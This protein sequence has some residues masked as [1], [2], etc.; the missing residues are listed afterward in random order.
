VNLVLGRAGESQAGT[1]HRSQVPGDFV[2]DNPVWAARGERRLRGDNRMLRATGV[3]C[4][5]PDED[6]LAVCK[7]AEVNPIAGTRG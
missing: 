4:Q 3:D 2:R 5:P 1:C 6:K 7:C